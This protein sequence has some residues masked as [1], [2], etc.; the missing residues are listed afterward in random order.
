MLIG[1]GKPEVLIPALIKSLEG[2]VAGVWAQRE[3]TLE[4]SRTLDNV[5]EALPS[6]VE[7]KLN[8]SKT[9]IP[10]KHLPFNPARDTPDVYTAFRKK[11]E[12][13]GLSLGEGMLVQPLQTAKWETKGKEVLEVVVSVGKQ[14]TKLKP[15]PKIEKLEG[16]KGS[17]WVEKGSDG[18]SLEGMYNK[19]SKPLFDKPPIGGWSSAAVEG[20][21]PAVHAN[22]AV[23]F[24][25]GEVSALSRLEDY[26]GHSTGDG[27]Q[28]GEK[29]KTYKDTRNGLIGEGFST[30]F[31]SLLSL[32]ILS[33]R[34]AGWRVG[35]LLELVNKDKD[36]RNNVYCEFT[37]IFPKLR[38]TPLTR[39]LLLLQGSYLNFSGAT[40]S[41]SPPSNMPPPSLPRCSTQRGS[42]RRS[43][44][45]Q[46][47]RGRSR[48]SGIPQISTIK[49]IS[50]EDGAREEREFRLLTRQ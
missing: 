3:Y 2:D 26:L 40:T 38:Q 9:M 13:M 1:Y 43:S 45:T 24:P 49:R 14:D 16:A 27:W 6:G 50:Q 41:S 21:F 34:E 39:L 47:T 28:G 35:E 22:S 46:R 29:A 7:M 8:D 17:G 42:R 15:F 12:G 31:A 30:K 5:A 36:K 23:P 48:R 18:D 11:V 4:E 19:L 20:Q 32:G 10:P 33:A 44:C 37:S 25:G